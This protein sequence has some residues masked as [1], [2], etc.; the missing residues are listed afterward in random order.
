MHISYHKTQCTHW[1]HHHHHHHHLISYQYIY[2]YICIIFI[3]LEFNIILEQIKVIASYDKTTKSPV[4]PPDPPWCCR[5]FL[6][7]S[8]SVRQAPHPARWRSWSPRRCSPQL[9]QRCWRGREEA[10]PAVSTHQL[11]YSP[12]NPN[13]TPRKINMEPTNHLF[14]KENDLPNLHDCVPC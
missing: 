12:K 9:Q 14:G 6:F 3:H 8:A 11:Y 4:I 2:I 10:E 1:K 13:P 5:S 7:P